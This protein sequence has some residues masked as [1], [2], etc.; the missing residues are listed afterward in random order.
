VNASVAR[1]HAVIDRDSGT[2][3]RAE[4]RFDGTVASNGDPAS[5]DAHVRY[6]FTVGVDVTRPPVI[7]APSLGESAWKLLVY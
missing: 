5:V 3:E 1:A 4:V 2:L 6:E 7:G